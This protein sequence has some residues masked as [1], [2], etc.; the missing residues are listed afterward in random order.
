MAPGK[1]GDDGSFEV[2]CG[3]GNKTSKCRE[4]KWCDTV[5]RCIQVP[6]DHCGNEKIKV[7]KTLCC[8][9][10]KCDHCKINKKMCPIHVRQRNLK[11]RITPEDQCVPGDEIE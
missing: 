10:V 5:T 8:D 3:R 7:Q 9:E 4:D 2:K 6:L 11:L 1:K